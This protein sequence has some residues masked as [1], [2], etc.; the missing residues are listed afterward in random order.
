ME[1]RFLDAEGDLACKLMAALQGAKMV[2][3]DSRCATNGTSSLFA[4]VKVAQPADTFGSPS[5]LVSVRTKNGQNIEPIDTLQT[6]FDLVHDCSSVKIDEKDAFGSNYKLYPNPANTELNIECLVA[7][8]GSN[9]FNIQGITGTIIYHDK[10]TDQSKLDVSGYSAGLY[11]IT[12]R[13]G[14]STCT[15]KFLK[16]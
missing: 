6:L 10:F 9:E 11:F 2:G 1:A 4:F 3:A 13:N 12:I 14:Y 7:G 5:F 16:E 8:Q 15:S